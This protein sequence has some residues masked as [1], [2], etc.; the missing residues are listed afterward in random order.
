MIHL[1]VSHFP[2][3]ARHSTDVH[4]DVDVT[5]HGAHDAAHS[6]EGQKFFTLREKL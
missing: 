1:S 6:G 5:E 2:S 4:L 3:G